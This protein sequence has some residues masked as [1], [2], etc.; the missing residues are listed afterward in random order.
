MYLS[1]KKKRNISLKAYENKKII[2]KNLLF[3]IS[4]HIFPKR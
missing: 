3:F 4:K 2:T 1:K